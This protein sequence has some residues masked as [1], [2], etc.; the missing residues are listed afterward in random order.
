MSTTTDDATILVRAAEIVEKGWCQGA[1]ARDAKGV[2]VAT[3]DPRATRWCLIG[4]IAKAEYE[5]K[6]WV[7][8]G[9]HTACEQ[10]CGG[11]GLTSFNDA[12][13]RTAAQ[14]AAALRRAAEEK[15]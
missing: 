2:S 10:A 8:V 12:P 5:L 1:T 4:A 13:G 3:D 15:S 11:S 7:K 9:G 6:G 14:V